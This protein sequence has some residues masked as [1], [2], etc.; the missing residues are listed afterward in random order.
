MPPKLQ[1]D[2][3]PRDKILTLYQKLTLDSRK[4]FQADLANELECSS[5]TVARLIDLVDRHLTK[6]VQIERGM[7]GRRRYYQLSCNS[8]KHGLGFSFEELHFL[9][10]CR[11][12]AT[13]FLSKDATDRIGKTLAN[14]ALGLGEDS[15]TSVPIRFHSKGVI[16]Y[17]PHLT[18]LSML[19]EAI[20]HKKICEI[21]YI[22]TGRKIEKSY[23]YAPGRI[24]IMGGTIYVHGYQM[25]E[26]SLLP[27]R[28]TTFSLHRI[29][30]I[31][32]AQEYFLFNADADEVRCFGLSWHEPLRMKI[33]IAPQAADYVRDRIWSDDQIIED[34]PDGS[35]TLTFVTTSQK[36]VN[37]WVMSFGKLAHIVE[38]Y[39]PRTN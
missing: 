12:L 2:S 28:P 22:A 25:E 9:A 32:T 33:H 8:I 18:T 15:P 31:T 35:L 21:Q 23:R 4:H 16:D 5:Q 34:H 10:I 19:R 36:E 37:A 38:P 29:T 14:I 17:T 26:T 39:L 20:K 24:L 30:Q 3:L 1:Q 7:D 6:D 13:P 27:G 11:D